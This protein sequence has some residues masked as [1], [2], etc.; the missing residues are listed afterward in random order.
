[1]AQVTSQKSK[2]YLVC[3]HAMAHA[4][5]NLLYTVARSKDSLDVLE[6]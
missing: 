1:M 6:L 4:I 3:G 5:D 2:T